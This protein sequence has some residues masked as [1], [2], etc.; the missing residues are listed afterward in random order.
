VEPICKANTQAN[1]QILKGVRQKV[2]AG[3]LDA[4]ARQ[5]RGAAR[6]LR[7][8]VGQ[9]KGVAQPPADRERLAKWIGLIETEADLFDRTAAKLAADDKIGAQRMVIRLTHN[10]N[11]ANNQV[12]VFEFNY[13]R[14]DPSKFT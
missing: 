9:L 2:K 10:A 1:Q 14:L 5:F 8:T 12:L 4:A 3:K 13:C 7:K 6:A 11:V